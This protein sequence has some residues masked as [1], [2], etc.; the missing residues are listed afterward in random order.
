MVGHDLLLIIGHALL[1]EGFIIGHV[2]NVDRLLMLGT[3][4]LRLLPLVGIDAPSHLVSH[5]C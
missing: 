2:K 3:N 4:C 1:A 5:Y